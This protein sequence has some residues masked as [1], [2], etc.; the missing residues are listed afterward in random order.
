MSY[1]LVL[2]RKVVVH[3]HYLLSMSLSDT[4]LVF[5]QVYAAFLDASKA[6]DKVLHNALFV[7]LLRHPCLFCT[8]AY[9]LV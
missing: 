4:S 6:C 8:V 7:K 9:Q 1:S 5:R 3:M 2:K